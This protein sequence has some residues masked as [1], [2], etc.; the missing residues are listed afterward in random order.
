MV[1]SL[2]DAEPCFPDTWENISGVRSALQGLRADLKIIREELKHILEVM[3]RHQEVVGGHQQTLTCLSDEVTLSS[4]LRPIA[5]STRSAFFAIAQQ[6]QG[7]K[8]SEY[9]RTLLE[10]EGTTVEPVGDVQ[11]DVCFFRKGL[12]KEEETFEFLYGMDWR[13]AAEVTGSSIYLQTT[14]PCLPHLSNRT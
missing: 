10:L 9:Q 1:Q 14:L 12:I 6:D 13:S 3:E 2:E 11:T 7:N 8:V 4:P 5:L